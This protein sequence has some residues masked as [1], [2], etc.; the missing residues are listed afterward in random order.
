MSGKFSRK[1]VWQLRGT[2]VIGLYP[3]FFQG[4]E[5]K[6]SLK[7][8]GFTLWQRKLTGCGLIAGQT[9]QNYGYPTDFDHLPKQFIYIFH[10]CM[11]ISAIRADLKQGT[12]NSR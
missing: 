6:T 1:Q 7:R 12:E 11:G 5:R 10:L 2:G 9:R 3:Y 4:D 8:E